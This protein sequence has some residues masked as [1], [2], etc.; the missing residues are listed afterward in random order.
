MLFDHG[1]REVSI[2]SV[3]IHISRNIL[4]ITLDDEVTVQ[5]RTTHFTHAYRKT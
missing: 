5:A 2:F 4:V 1:A 3:S